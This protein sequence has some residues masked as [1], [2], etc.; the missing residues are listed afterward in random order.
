MACGL[1]IWTVVGLLAAS[2]LVVQAGPLPPEWAG[3]A[4]TWTLE[5]EDGENFSCDIT[6]LDEQG[7]GGYN[8]V[9][10]DACADS[11]PTSDIAG[12]R[13]NTDTYEVEFIDALRQT[14]LALGEMGDGGLYGSDIADPP[15]YFLVHAEQ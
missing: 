2:P 11:F 6:L 7:I 12:W 10:P 1:K 9:I 3:M 8:L 13:I 14:V 5:E 4:G 15:Q